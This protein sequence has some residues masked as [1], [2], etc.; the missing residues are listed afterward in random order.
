[1]TTEKLIAEYQSR[2]TECDKAI[3]GLTAS[4]K[5][6]RGEK[7]DES[8]IADI[9]NERKVEDAKRQAYFQFIKNLEDL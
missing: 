5:K 8:V 2:V 4:I 6:A 1:M 7:E 3:E 9:A